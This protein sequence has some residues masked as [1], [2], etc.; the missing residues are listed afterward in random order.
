VTNTA[1]DPIVRV[2]GVASTGGNTIITITIPAAAG[3]G[4]VIVNAPGS[5][6]ATVSNAFP[7]DLVGTFGTVPGAHPDITSVT[8]TTIDAL[9]P[10][11]AETI[12]LTGTNLDLATAV[13]LDGVGIPPSR[14]TIVGP[15]TITL[16][17]PQASSLGAHNLGV[18]DGPTTDQ[19][20]V[21]IVAPATPKLEWGT[22]DAL[23]VIDRDN[24]LDMIVSGI[25]GRAHA[26]RGSPNG[27][28]SLRRIRPIDQILIDA[29]TYVIPPAGWLAIHLDHLPDPALVGSTWFAKSF[30]LTP[31]KPFPSSN[32]QS[33]TLVP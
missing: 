3:P 16:D 30:D 33:I 10:G 1:A 22:G 27:P 13:L 32:D 15:T 26:V 11:T 6:N 12:T 25:P 4:D 5:G 19:F 28:P 7:T 9:I 20:A 21:T 14:Y 8:P 29:G 2:T 24:G 23:N 18:T 17:M 31:P